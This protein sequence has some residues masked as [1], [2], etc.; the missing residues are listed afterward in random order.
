MKGSKQHLIGPHNDT[1]N[2]ASSIAD[3]KGCFGHQVLVGKHK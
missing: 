1:I 3:I 2:L